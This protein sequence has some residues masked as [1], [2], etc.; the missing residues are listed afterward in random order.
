VHRRAHHLIAA[1]RLR[2]PTTFADAFA[3]L[4]DAGLLDSEVADEAARM[5]GFRNVLVHQY[6]EVDDARV[7]ALL[8]TG[9]DDLD[10][11]R[12]ALAR[13]AQA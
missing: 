6:A 7:A 2:R 13:A 10:V 1:Q 4:A 5:A 12:Q 9:L 8:H 11:L 3:V